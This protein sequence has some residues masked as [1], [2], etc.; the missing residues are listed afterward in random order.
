MVVT[1]LTWHQVLHSD[2]GF[3]LLYGNNLSESIMHAT[4]EALQPYPRG[5]GFS[6]TCDMD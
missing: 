5:Q 3:V 1:Q 6:L 4:V 2:I